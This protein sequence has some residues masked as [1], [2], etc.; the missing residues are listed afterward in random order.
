MS[1][2]TWQAF[3]LCKDTVKRQ[4]FLLL[5]K[6]A[7]ERLNQLG[8]WKDEH[9]QVHFWLFSFTE[10]LL[11]VRHRA[12]ERGGDREIQRT[13]MRNSLPERLRLL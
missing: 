11:G 9:M 6:D 3:L 10:A 4:A 13:V 2:H 1:A 12:G 8:S 7:V 5:C